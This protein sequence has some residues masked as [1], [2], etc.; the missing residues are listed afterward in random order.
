[1][2]EAKRRGLVAPQRASGPRSWKS[3]VER[4]ARAFLE[5]H[6]LLLG[7]ICETCGYVAGTNDDCEKCVKPP[8][9]AVEDFYPGL[10]WP[11]PK[12]GV[13]IPVC[14][15]PA[16]M[17]SVYFG[18]SE[19]HLASPLPWL[20]FR[21]MRRERGRTFDTL[22]GDLEKLTLFRALNGDARRDAER[23]FQRMVTNL[24]GL[25]AREKACGGRTP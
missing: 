18:V 14:E 16:A 17:Y 1:M 5:S 20:F 4:E 10:P 15:S 7:V 23:I 2:S 21:P 25:A 3:G 22:A 8:R 24:R 12:P 11:P 6:G 19:W 9:P 13:S